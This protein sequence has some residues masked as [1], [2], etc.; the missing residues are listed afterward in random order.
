MNREE[1]E[2]FLRQATGRVCVRYY[3]RHDGTVLTRDCPVG[4]GIVRRARRR[5]A[6]AAASAFAVFTT[7]LGMS[8]R[9][10][11]LASYDDVWR[12]RQPEPVRR[13]LNAIDPP[14]PMP[15]AGG[16]AM[17][18]PA[19]PPEPVMGK[20]AAMMGEVAVEPRPVETQPFPQ[21]G[22]MVVPAPPTGR[23]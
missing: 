7:G 9:A 10:G 4:V 18:T 22:R 12:S 15:I 6:L 11:Q 1:A 3:Q 8:L 21:Q 2:A 5:L 20:P 16:I 13:V 19:A 23:K 17:G 14:E